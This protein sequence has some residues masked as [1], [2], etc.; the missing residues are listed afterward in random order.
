[1][2]EQKLEHSI[3]DITKDLVFASN[4]VME[5]KYG[6]A[7]PILRRIYSEEGLR[8]HEYDSELFRDLQYFYAMCL[9]HLGEG[10]EALFI[11]R[12]SRNTQILDTRRHILITLCQKTP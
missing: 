12:R 7:L 8:I 2:N 9:F 4:L 5:E 11:L 6:E 10:H 3:H 1:M